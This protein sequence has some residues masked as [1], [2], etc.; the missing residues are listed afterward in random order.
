[1]IYFLSTLKVQLLIWTLV[2][3]SS[4][5]ESIKGHLPDINVISHFLEQFLKPYIQSVKLNNGSPFRAK[6][7]TAIEKAIRK[8]IA[9]L[10][11]YLHDE[12][13]EENNL[14]ATINETDDNLALQ[15]NDET[16]II[17]FVPKQNMK[18]DIKK[19]K[20]KSV[21]KAVNDDKDSFRK[22]IK[23]YKQ[24]RETIK[25]LLD[26]EGAG[27][28]TKKVITR[29][30]D[31]MLSQMVESQ[32]TWKPPEKNTQNH[33]FRTQKS[34]HKSLDK[35]HK[36]SNQEWKNLR[37]QYL[38]FLK[39]RKHHEDSFINQFHDF[40][41][42][43]MND[44]WFLSSHYKVKCQLVKIGED[45]GQ[46]IVLR[47][48]QS[49]DKNKCEG[50]KI[51]S[52]ELKEFLT[53][54]YKYVND[55]AV[56]TFR[57]YAAMYIRDVNVDFGLDKD[58]VV[59][60]IENLSNTVEKKVSKL[61]K[62]E[63]EKFTLDEEKRKNENIQ[64]INNFISAIIDR[65]KKTL[66]KS[67]DGE[68]GAMKTKLFVTVKDDLNVNLKVDMDNLQKL[69]VDRICTVFLLCN[70]K[71]ASR[72]QQKPFSFGNKD[73]DNI[74]VKVQLTLDDELKDSIASS[75]SLVQAWDGK[76]M[77]HRLFNNFKIDV[78]KYDGLNITRTTISSNAITHG[79]IIK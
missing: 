39:F 24:L 72:R 56:S 30:L 22:N 60:V 33:V 26:K 27:S 17:E 71:Y 25:H 1:M 7:E 36:L 6:E 70:G 11:P 38:N 63:L 13:S 2:Y 66:K 59:T 42:D 77:T 50:F 9:G 43:M 76:D 46:K 65:A 58:I 51:C 29:T 4:N 45:T 68:L 21:M 69:F 10:K 40:F 78:K 20:G 74:Y 3:E 67:L 31:D 23:K 48:D 35:L 75:G 64:H 14:R 28:K 19:Y 18:R 57:N 52:N 8:K 47:Q 49:L 62:K 44:T 53:N 55:T 73:T 16:T 37:K 32:C 61:F 12:E 15:G 41:S 5:S 54:F 34:T 79:K